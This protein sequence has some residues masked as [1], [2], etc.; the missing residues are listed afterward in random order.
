[1][2]NMLYTIDFEWRTVSIYCYIYFGFTASA[3]FEKDV[4]NIE[5]HIPG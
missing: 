1:M 3:Y 4:L 5:I 2:N